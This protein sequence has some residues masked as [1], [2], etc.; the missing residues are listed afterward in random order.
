MVCTI[1]KWQAIKLMIAS[2]LVA[3]VVALGVY[4][5]NNGEYWWQTSVAALLLTPWIMLF[6]MPEADTPVWCKGC[7]THHT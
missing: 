3:V 2:F 4:F 7:G 6:T 1:R 5:L